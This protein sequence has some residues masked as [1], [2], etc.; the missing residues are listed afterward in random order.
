MDNITQIIIT[1]VTVAGSAGIW[2]FL[3]ARLKSRNENKK[4]EL[5][6][7]DGIQYR[8]DLKNRV[9]NLESMLA[10]SSDE[11]DKLRDQVLQLV[12]EV[13]SLRVEVD[14]LKKENERLKNK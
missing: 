8:D 7:N 1:I 14:Y 13:N 11:K 2:K 12:A 4:I 5:Q 6:N 3:E 9:R 10:N